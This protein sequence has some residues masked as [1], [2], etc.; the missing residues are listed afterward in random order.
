L[1][2]PQPPAP[3]LA[4]TLAPAPFLAPTLAPA[5]SQQPS[6]ASNAQR[7]YY[8]APTSNVSPYGDMGSHSGLQNNAYTNQRSYS[9]GPGIGTNPPHGHGHG[10]FGAIGYS[11][12]SG[13]SSDHTR[14]S[15]RSS[16]FGESANGTQP[17][18]EANQSLPHTCRCSACPNGY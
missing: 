12:T 5:P 13:S 10:G 18:T 8:G 6:F 1:N 3:A 9:S 4:P 14:H 7:E 15:T 11:S 16:T 2:I 17:T